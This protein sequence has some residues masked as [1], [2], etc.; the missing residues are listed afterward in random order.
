MAAARDDQ[1]DE[2]TSGRPDVGRDFAIIDIA[3]ARQWAARQLD[4]SPGFLKPLQGQLHHFASALA[5][6]NPLTARGRPLNDT[7]GV[8]LGAPL[9][10]L[11]QALL[12]DA[13]ASGLVT[14]IV[15]SEVQSK[16]DPFTDWAIEREVCFFGESVIR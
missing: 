8:Q 16:S 12:T 6:A 3:E 7:G 5:V 9:L 13:A 2:R 1:P 11:T 15:E 4:G 14:V 10:E